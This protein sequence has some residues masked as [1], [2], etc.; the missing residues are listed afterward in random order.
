LFRRVDSV[1]VSTA[2]VDASL[3]DFI[4]SVEMIESVDANVK[5]GIIDDVP[6]F[7]SVVVSTA[8][9]DASLVGFIAS[10]EVI[11]SVDANVVT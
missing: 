1:V 11:E 10:V 5:E 8:E 4:A 6:S 7:A 9:V 2:V 3:V